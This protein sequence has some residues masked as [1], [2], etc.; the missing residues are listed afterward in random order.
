MHLRQKG[1]ER[2][3]GQEVCDLPWDPIASAATHSQLAGVIAGL[4]F[5][6]IVVI[7]QRRESG[8]ADGQAI[9]LF[10]IGFAT[11]ALDSFLFGVVAGER[12]CDRAWTETMAAAGILGIGAIG[13]FT[14]ISWLLVG[15]DGVGS[16]AVRVTRHVAYVIAAIVGIHITVTARDFLHDVHPRLDTGWITAVQR[17]YIAI[18]ILIIIVHDLLRRR[19]APA[20]G[21]VVNF[22]AYAALAYVAT[23]SAVFA[24]LAGMPP[25]DWDDGGSLRR[26]VT[27]ACIAVVLP[28][29]ALIAQLMALPESKL[30]RTRSQESNKPEA[31]SLDPPPSQSPPPGNSTVWT[32]TFTRRRGG[33]PDSRTS[34]TDPTRR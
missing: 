32:I 2:E 12:L 34:S 1:A 15:H 13:L 24:V 29:F 22:A 23:T 14:G 17:I 27:V 7:L 30:Q 9:V 18:V 33:K 5:G 25:E 3:M 31:V 8:F 19:I 21:Q 4:V 10:V 20:A 11:F 6:G 26:S 16:A 28:L